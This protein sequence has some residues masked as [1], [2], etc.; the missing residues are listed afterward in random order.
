MRSARKLFYFSFSPGI[1]LLSKREPFVG[2]VSSRWVILFV[3]FVFLN[4]F[5]TLT[6]VLVI[7]S[8]EYL[9]NM[10]IVLATLMQD[11]MYNFPLKSDHESQRNCL[12]KS[13]SGNRFIYFFGFICY[14]DKLFETKEGRPSYL[15]D[16]NPKL[17]S[18]PNVSIMFRECS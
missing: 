8:L 5:R 3:Q 2:F 12:S 6:D 1:L 16:W 14:L 9:S 11:R 13:S 10:I 17:L 4:V 18:G 7:C 15:Q